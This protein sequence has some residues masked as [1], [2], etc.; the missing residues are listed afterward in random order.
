MGEAGTDEAALA[1]GP[2][3]EV[4][5][6]RDIQAGDVEVTEHLGFM[7]W[8]EAVDALGVD[9]EGVFNDEVGNHLADGVTFVCRFVAGLLFKLNV[10]LSELDAEGALVEFFIQA[11]AQRLMHRNGCGDDLAG[12][13]LVR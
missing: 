7:L 13:F 2:G 11:R 1:E 6:Q 9:D 5:E 10:S 4:E 8:R 3:F 12:E